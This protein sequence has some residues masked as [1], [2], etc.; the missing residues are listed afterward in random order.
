MKTI[1]KLKLDIIFVSAILA[2]LGVL[3]LLNPDK[4]QDVICYVLAGAAIAAGLC[5]VIDYLRKDA[6]AD[7]MRYV[8]AVAM[9]AV[10]VGVLMLVRHDSVTRYLPTVLSFLILFSGAV[11][12]QNSWDMK[13]LKHSSWPVHSII[14]LIGVVVGFI[15]MMGWIENNVTTWIGVGLI[16][17]GFTDLVSALVLSRIRKLINK[18]QGEVNMSDVNAEDVKPQPEQVYPENEE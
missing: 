18:R 7:E 17:S 6:L 15:L 8:L 3:M 14:A 1:K 4:T 5:F 10:L 12:F 2:G 11:K 9:T 16:Y 13:R